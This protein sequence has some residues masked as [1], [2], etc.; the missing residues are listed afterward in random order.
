M[1]SGEV[2]VWNIGN[3]QKPKWQL[4]SSDTNCKGHSRIVFSLSAGGEHFS[5]LLSI[6]MD[7]QV[8][9]LFACLMPFCL[10]KFLEQKIPLLLT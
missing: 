4:M 2:A 3:L 1:C 5:K 6:S 8:A 7:R 9:L 10:W